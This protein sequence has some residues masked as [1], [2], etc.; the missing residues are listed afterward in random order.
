MASL[1]LEVDELKM[2]QCRL[3]K[4]KRF[5]RE[6][7]QVRPAKIFNRRRCITC[8]SDPRIRP[9]ARQ[10]DATTSN[11]EIRHVAPVCDSCS[12]L[13][14]SRLF[15]LRSAQLEGRGHAAWTRKA[16]IILTLAHPAAEMTRNV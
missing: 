14:T 4:E 11:F 12:L 15:S 13:T 3:E 5:L 16:L 8:P 7:T 2:V 10:L 6:E 1:Q 9:C